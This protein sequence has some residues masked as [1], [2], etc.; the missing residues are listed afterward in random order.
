MWFS[1]FQRIFL[2]LSL[3]VPGAVYSKTR[4]VRTKCDICV[5]VHRHHTWWENYILFVSSLLQFLDLIIWTIILNYT[6]IYILYSI[7]L[8]SIMIPLHTITWPFNL[9]R[10]RFPDFVIFCQ[11]KLFSG[12]LCC[13]IFCILSNRYYYCHIFSFK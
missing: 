6:C 5:F 7:W 3:S 12:I 9:L 1:C 13:I 11:K 8:F 4:V 2:Y 10:N